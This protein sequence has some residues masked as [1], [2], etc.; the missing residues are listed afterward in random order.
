MKTRRAARIDHD[1]S[2]IGFGAW[3]LG[4]Q[5]GGA[6][7]GE[8]IRA[9]HAALDA[10]VNFIDT[11]AVYGDGRSERVIAEALKGRAE[12]PFIA[13]KTPPDEG[14]WPPSPYCDHRERY[15]PEYLRA[16]VE[17]RLKN[18]NVETID[19]LQLH[20]WTRAWNADPQPFHEL[21]KLRD[22]GKIRYV[23]VS[24][25]EHDQNAVLSLMRDGLVDAV[26]VIF[27]AWEQE[28]AAELLP[29]A[30]GLGVL[31]IVRV[32]LD[33]GSLTGKYGPDK[34]FPEDD[35]RVNYFAGDRMRRTAERV[36]KLE[37]D[38][39]AAG[40]PGDRTMTSAALQFALSPP[41]VTSVIAGMRTRQ[42]AV[43]NAAVPDLPPLTDE[44]LAVFRDHRWLRA[45]WYG[46]K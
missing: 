6:D 31:V 35:F 21:A 34:T 10:G 9:L 37:A 29:L 16:N 3:Q 26:Q 22:E 5:W 12:T 19:L 18:L 45:F 15:S 40:L 20:T 43:Q 7:D 27:N 23:G 39:R 42:H 2:E 24:T 17:T 28:P 30:E 13:T 4:G 32:A 11:A 38:L 46:G 8:S 41:A 44:Q 1:F 25:P 14:P 33:E 36:R